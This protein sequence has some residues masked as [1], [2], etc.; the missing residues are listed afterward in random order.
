MTALVHFCRAGGLIAVLLFVWFAVSGAPVVAQ[1]QRSAHQAGPPEVRAA[2][3]HDTSRPLTALPQL[4]PRAAGAVLRRKVLP[5]RIGSSGPTGDGAVQDQG[6]PVATVPQVLRNFEGVGNVNGVLPPDPTGD[7]GPNHYVQMVNLSFAVWDRNGTRLYGPADNKTLWQGFGGPCEVS[8]DGDPIV[9]YDHL[10]DRWILSQLALPNFPT[11]PFYQCIAVSKTGDPTGQYHRYEFLISETKLNDYPKFG[12]WPDGYYMAVN[13]FSC[14]PVFCTWAGQGAVA[15]ER[16]RILNGEPAR[17]VYFDLHATDPNLGGMLPADLDG[18]T[19]PGGTPNLFCQIDDD[20]WGY[21]PDQMQ[22]WGFRV[23]WTTPAGSSLSHDAVLPTAA[24][25]SNLCWYGRNCI[26]QAGT[27]VKVDALS[28]RLMY[29]L[30]YRYYG[31]HETIVVNHS[32]DVDG[33]DRAGVRWY[34]LRNAGGGWSIFQQGT[35]APVGLH[36]WMGSA[37]MN[38]IGDLAIGFS[39]SSGSVSPSIAA[40]GRLAGDPLGTM[41]Q[42]ELMIRAGSGYQTH[43]S[44]RWGDYSTLAVDPTDDCT[45]W[46]T[47]EYYAVAGAAPWQTSVGAFKLRD[48]EASGPPPEEPPAPPPPPTVHVG[49]LDGSV[50]TQK[51]LWT[52]AVTIFV[53]DGAHALAAG[54]TVTGNWSGATAGVSSCT[55][56]NS[57]RCTLARGGIRKSSRSATFTVTGLTRA[58]D[59]YVPAQNHDADGDSTG[60][61]LTVFKP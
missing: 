51:N 41:T 13:Q 6:A 2:T 17:M 37:A 59:A 50:T 5:N 22:C 14:Y 1:G 57:G 35:Y 33:S 29:R 15:F 31:T 20:A 27:T 23:N 11:G 30:Q 3:R 32:V 38:G 10:A 55:T 16:E 60:T 52:A 28:D 19:P 12:L 56:D 47:Q 26:P 53:H 25:D 48:C 4:P 39:V 46:Y 54:A 9:L 43:S 58:A 42:G 61:A 45:F 21:S 24:F 34:E 40:T 18:A 8:E 7:I 49:D 36:R 44:G